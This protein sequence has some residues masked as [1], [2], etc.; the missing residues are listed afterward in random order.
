M[1]KGS[2]ASCNKDCGNF[3]FLIQIPG[4][5]QKRSD[6]F[7][8]SCNYFLHKG[9]PYHK[10]CGRC[11][12]IQK[13]DPA[14]GFHALN[15]P[16]CLRGTAAG[17]LCWETAGVFFVRKIID[18]KGNIHILNKSSVFWTKL[19]G[20]TV[21]DYIFSAVSR[22][23]IINAQLKGIKKRGFTVI[24]A[25][26]DQS[27]PLRDPHTGYGSS[28]GKLHGNAQ[29]VRRPERNGIFHGTGRNSAFSRK[30]GTVCHKSCKRA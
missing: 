27:D 10:I 20:G 14:S 6:G 11:V 3:G 22:Y 5:F 17:I 21:C 26:Y 29:R 30:D 19:Q 8:F 13:K 16:G 24:A 7:L 18:K 25:S 23:M 15:D 28:V 9:I 12:F 4:P 1:K 2:W